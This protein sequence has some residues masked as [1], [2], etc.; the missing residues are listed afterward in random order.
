M[1]AADPNAMWKVQ[2]F[3]LNYDRAEIEAAARVVES[4]W[5]TMGDKSSSSRS[6]SRR[7]P[8]RA[9][10][11]QVPGAAAGRVHGGVQLHRRAAHGG[12]GRGRG[13]GDEVVI[14]ALTFVADANVVKLA[15]PSRCWP[16]ARVRRSSR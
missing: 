8:Q 2:L 11:R 13:P 9:E 4:G 10:R 16:T 3:K 7:V 12:A 5:L 15:A 14:P 1:A 6:A